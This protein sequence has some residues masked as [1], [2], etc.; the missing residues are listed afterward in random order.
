MKEIRIGNTVEQCVERADYPPERVE[1]I[2]GNEIV[3][4]LGYGVQGRGQ[5]L[6]MSDN[7]VNVIVGLRKGGKAWDLASKTAGCRA[8]RS[9]TPKR[10]PRRAPSS[11]T[12]SP[13]PGQKDM[14]PKLKPHLT[15]GKALYF[16]HGF[17]IVFSDQTGVI[18]PKDIDVILVRPEGL[19]HDGPPALPR[20]PGHQRQLRHPPG[21]DRPGPRP[22]P[23]A[24]H[25]HRLGLPVRDDLPEGSRSAT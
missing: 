15:K 10:P 13:T 9:S 18:P 14:W 23:G 8:R 16:S 7:G 21:R 6:N 19:G 12:C 22:L 17:S 1:Q 4:V 3:A 24:R 11:S 5:S 20:R 2:L 25:R